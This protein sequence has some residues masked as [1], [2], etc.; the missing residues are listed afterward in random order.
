MITI[1]IDFFKGKKTYI[2]GI[3]MVILGYLNEDNQM[4]LTGLGLMTLR[5]GIGKV[6]K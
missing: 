6:G 2:I 3:L 1:I 4:I 5:A